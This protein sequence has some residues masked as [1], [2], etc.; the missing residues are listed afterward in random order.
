MAFT[1]NSFGKKKRKSGNFNNR[2][3]YCEIKS[4]NNIYGNA[5]KTLRN[6]SIQEENKLGVELTKMDDDDDIC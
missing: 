6:I 1:R 3:I 4:M 2:Y 5:K